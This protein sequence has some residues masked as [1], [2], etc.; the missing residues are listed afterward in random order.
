MAITI[1]IQKEYF[2]VAH[3]KLEMTEGGSTM[4]KKGYPAQS[5]RVA[6]LYQDKEARTETMFSHHKSQ[7]INPN[8]YPYF[9]LADKFNSA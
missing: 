2:D 5:R 6:S 4:T 3:D 7:T 1:V 9:F 8:S